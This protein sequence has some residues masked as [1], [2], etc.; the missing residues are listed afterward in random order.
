MASEYSYN[1][2]DIPWTRW[3]RDERGALVGERVVPDSSMQ[4][5]AEGAVMPTER[6]NHAESRQSRRPARTYSYPE[7]PV[8]SARAESPRPQVYMISRDEALR[9]QR[10]AATPESI[11]AMYSGANFL[12][13]QG[14]A[15]L[16][17]STRRVANTIFGLD[18]PGAEEQDYVNLGGTLL[19]M[20]M[21]R[22]AIPR[23]TP[24]SSKK[25]PGLSYRASRPLGSAKS[26]IARRAELANDLTKAEHPVALANDEFISARTA[27]ANATEAARTRATQAVTEDIFS[28]YDGFSFDY[29]A[30][31]R[32][33]NA[34]ADRINSL[35][36]RSPEVRAT[37][38][39]EVN[40]RVNLTRTRHAQAGKIQEAQAAL[41]ASDSALKLTPEEAAAWER[42][43]DRKTGQRVVARDNYMLY[44]EEKARPPTT[45]QKVLDKTMAALKW[46]LPWGHG[47][48]GNVA[49]GTLYSLVAGGLISSYNSKK[50]TKAQMEA[51]QAA[52]AEARQKHVN[53]STTAFNAI[54][55]EENLK[56]IAAD[57]GA[58]DFR[59]FQKALQTIGYA[60]GLRNHRDFRSA[61]NHV[62]EVAIYPMMSRL[63][64]DAWYN[65][66][67]A[68]YDQLD[69]GAKE[70]VREKYGDADN[71]DGM[72]AFAKDVFY[73]KTLNLEDGSK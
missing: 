17:S 31:S 30:L 40:A 8:M 44:R 12:D 13:L 25:G 32:D 45:G 16:G 37:G 7:R 62:D 54:G 5:R 24:V 38:R 55:S 23:G 53:D 56:K 34:A 11:K 26:K 36:S 22:R 64:Q 39:A 27:H 4:H 71:Y 2:A 58:R 68:Q 51:A 10:D 61:T 47:T 63:P 57:V 14:A 73:N 43:A 59:S 48:W 6:G 72:A 65:M 70:A 67:Q 52:S 1:Y 15:E 9:R 21:M 60:N 41:E 50:V 49:L 42:Y 29:D 3:S 28:R 20:G 46:S 66:G 35:V 19:T 33:V 69:R 18:G